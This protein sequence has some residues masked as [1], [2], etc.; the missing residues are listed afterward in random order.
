MSTAFIKKWA[1]GC[2]SGAKIA[3]KK[4]KRQNQSKRKVAK[5][6]Y[7]MYGAGDLVDRMRDNRGYNKF[8]RDLYKNIDIREKQVMSA[9][10][11]EYV[12]RGLPPA[13]YE[14]VDERE[15]G[16]NLFLDG[17]PRAK[18]DYFFYLGQHTF[19]YEIKFNN[20][21]NGTFYKDEWG[22]ETIYVKCGAIISM[23][24]HPT[25]YPNG[26]L[27]VSTRER[28]LILNAQEVADNF[29][30]GEPR[31][32]STAIYSKKAY[33]IPASEVENLWRDWAVS[34]EDP[35]M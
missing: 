29:N 28:F 8:K 30:I 19:T 23:C 2:L 10:S 6:G 31:Q 32:Y 20:S 27:I 33:F 17:Q 25:L 12:M 18:P 35:V 34:I 22:N 1:L 24:K 7:G 5:M 13:S 16:G 14:K 4:E 26:R 15:G 11:K 9:L 3:G 21:K